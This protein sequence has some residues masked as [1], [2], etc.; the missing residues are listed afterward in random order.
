MF[1]VWDVRLRAKDPLISQKE[2]ILRAA[3][4]SPLRN[5]GVEYFRQLRLPTDAARFSSL[6]LR[7]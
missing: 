5:Q 2:K 1:A 7:R 3:G 6:I 4:K